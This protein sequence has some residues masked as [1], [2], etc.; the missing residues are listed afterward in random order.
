MFHPNKTGGFVYPYL[1]ITATSLQIAVFFLG[2]QG[3]RLRENFNW[4]LKFALLALAIPTPS[5]R[6][7]L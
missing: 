7:S 1:C 4:Q 6:S 5:T 2:P 3:G